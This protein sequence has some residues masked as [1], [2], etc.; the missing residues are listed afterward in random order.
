V[1]LYSTHFCSTRKV[2]RRGSHSIT[3]NYTSAC[4]YWLGVHEFMSAQCLWFQRDYRRRRRR[5]WHATRDCVAPYVDFVTMALYKSVYLLTYLLR[6]RVSF[7]PPTCSHRV[8]DCLPQHW[9]SNF[10]LYL[11]YINTVC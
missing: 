8:W 1:Y 2:L 9:W 10:H 7:S 4:I 11:N 5:F 3:C 6:D